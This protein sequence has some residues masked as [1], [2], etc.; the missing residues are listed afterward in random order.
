MNNTAFRKTMGNVRNHR[1][2][3]LMTTEARN[4]YL[5]LELIYHKKIFFK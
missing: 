1:D 5:V 3:N 2:I 4:N